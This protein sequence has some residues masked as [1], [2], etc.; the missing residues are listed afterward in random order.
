[1]SDVGAESGPEDKSK[2]L[3]HAIRSSSESGEYDLAGYGADACDKLAEA[4]FGKPLP[5]AQMVRCSF[6]VGGGKKVR[7]RYNDGLPALL[8]DAL[9]KVGF[10]DI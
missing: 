10:A 5:L 7:Q 3:A 2:K 9:K 4:A 6:V 8:A 1:M